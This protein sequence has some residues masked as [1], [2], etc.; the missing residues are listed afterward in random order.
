MGRLLEIWRSWSVARRLALVGGVV[1]VV[2]GAAVAAYLV[3]RRPADVSN[4]HAAFHDQ[5]RKKKK[6]ETL[7]WPM[8]G[9]DHARTRYLP[10]K[11]LNPPFGS[12]LWSF[13]A[14]KLLEFQPIVVHGTIYF[15]DKDAT[16]YAL[17]VHGGHIEWKRDIGSLNASSPAYSDGKLFAVNL[18]PQQAVALDAKKKGKVLWKTPLPGRSESSPLVHQGRVIF[19]CESGEVFALDEKTGKVRWTAHTNGSVKGA[20][21]YDN[22][23]VFADNYAG[24]VYAID[25]GNGHVKWTAHTQGGGFLHGGGVYS[26]PAVAFGR[27]YLGGLDGRVYSFEEKTGQLAWSHSTGAEVYSSPAVADTPHAPPTVF[28]GSEDKHFY[29]LDAKTGEVRWE[30]PLNG[31]ILGSSSVVDRTVYVSVI[32]PNIGTFGFAVKQGQ[33]VFYNDQGEYNPVIS[34]GKRIYL[35][36]TSTI[37][38]FKPL[39]RHEQKTANRRRRARAANQKGHGA[40]GHKGGSHAKRGKAHGNKSHGN[41]QTQK[42][43][44]RG[45]KRKKSRG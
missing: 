10:V 38:A 13:Q 42:S 31:I 7:D 44:G 18:E 17:S 9:Y 34:D 21:A 23:T 22:G 36:G 1:L 35:T 37:R 28:I 2:A 14:G 5:K 27:V 32:G 3:T 6:P 11:G 24:E 30:H 25:A 19:G 12:S 39:T 15:M 45:G 41:N 4:P 20:L 43:A 29:A 8:Y 33:K 16:F 26:T 40:N